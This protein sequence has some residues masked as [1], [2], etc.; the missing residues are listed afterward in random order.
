[1]WHQRYGDAHAEVQAVRDVTDKTL[2][3]ESTV[4]VNLEPCSHTGKTPPCADMLVRERVKKVVIANKDTN[5]LVD[6]GGIKKLSAA[7]IEV[8]TGVL[9]AEARALNRRF[10]SFIEKKR[11]YIILKWA[12]TSDGFIARE[13]YD[14]KWISNEYARQLVHKWRTEED[15][16]LV[17]TNTARY[18]NPQLN[19]RDWS[20]RNP[21]RIVIDK[22]LML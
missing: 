10:F 9:E 16:V 15:A 6:G 12:Q 21:A 8:V 18:D 20:G 1:G 11:P 7:G 4:Y 13:N 19:V 2:L 3:P 17:G 22:S 14:S 5:P